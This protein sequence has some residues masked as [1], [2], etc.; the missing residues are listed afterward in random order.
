[1]TGG[2]IAGRSINNTYIELTDKRNLHNT[3]EELS[4]E[5][6]RSQSDEK[7]SNYENDQDNTYLSL[8]DQADIIS[9]LRTSKNKF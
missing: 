3:V 5:H 1:M 8:K 4:E 7:Y 2:S 6:L 9:Q